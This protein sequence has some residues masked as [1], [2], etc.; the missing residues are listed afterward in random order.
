MVDKYTVFEH[1]HTQ[2]LWSAG[3]IERNAVI[4]PWEIKMGV[5]LNKCTF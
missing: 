2:E 3:N 4:S 5:D 1:S